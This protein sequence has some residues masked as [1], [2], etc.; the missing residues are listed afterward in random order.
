MQINIEKVF[1]EWEYIGSSTNGMEF[2]GLAF[3]NM[4]EDGE[5]FV[6]YDY[7]LLDIGSS[8]LTSIPVEK[9]LELTARP[10]NKNMRVWFHKHPVG[11][12]ITG[13]HNWS[14]TDN[15]T[16]KDTPLGGIPELVRWSISVVRTPGGWVGRI[17]NHL[18]KETHHVDVV[19]KYDGLQETI[20][21]LRLAQAEKLA[22][23]LN[24][25]VPSQHRSVMHNGSRSEW[26]SPLWID[27]TYDTLWEADMNSF[28]YGFGVVTMTCPICMEGKLVKHPSMYD[29]YKVLVCNFIE[30]EVV[31]LEA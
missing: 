30:C 14:G 10:D 1:R 13:P 21:Q 25:T 27:E 4:S 7:I 22:V 6:V 19:P 8:S 26:V 15:N 9:V 23:V 3:G 17:D 20:T 5:S 28:D 12:G 24:G 11:N 31:F 29:A 18:T 16:I 2:S